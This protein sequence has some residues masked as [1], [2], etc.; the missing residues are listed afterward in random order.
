MSSAALVACAVLAVTAA[1]ASACG[2]SRR[3]IG[4]ECI[5]DED[6]LSGVCTN[7]ACASSPRL[8]TGAGASP[9]D[10]APRFPDDAAGAPVDAGGGG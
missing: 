3:P 2:E 9:P 7:R 6:C 5:R 1:A 8:V 4:E 10:D